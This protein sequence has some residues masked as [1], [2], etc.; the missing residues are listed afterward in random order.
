MKIVLAILRAPVRLLNWFWWYFGTKEIGYLAL[1]MA[2]VLFLG[3]LNAGRHVCT[4]TG[5]C[6]CLCPLS[7]G[8]VWIE[9]FVSLFSAEK[10]SQNWVTMLL[11]LVTWLVGGGA[12]VSVMVG[13]FYKKVAGELRWWP[14]L[15][16]DH[17]VVLGWDDGVLME[18]VNELKS[19]NPPSKCYVITSRPVKEIE[20]S[21]ESARISTSSICVYHGNYDD[22]REWKDNLRVRNAKRVFIMGEHEEDAHDARVRILFEKVNQEVGKGNDDSDKIRVNIHDFGLARELT[23]MNE[24]V[25]ENFHLNWANVLTDKLKG[26]SKGKGFDLYI[27]GFG[28]MG[29]AVAI[30]SVE[31]NL[32]QAIFVSDDDDKKL[33]DEKNRFIHQFADVS[34]GLD[35]GNS[36]SGSSL[37]AG[38]GA[39]DV[40]TSTPQGNR[41]TFNGVSIAFIDEW[42]QALKQMKEIFDYNKKSEDNN[43]AS[44]DDSQKCD[45]KN[46]AIVVAKKRSEKGMLCMMDVIRQL[47]KDCSN[48]VWLA[49]DQ[50]VDGYSV[51]SNMKMCIGNKIPVHLF[52]MKRGCEWQPSKKEKCRCTATQE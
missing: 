21:F 45:K 5:G 18:L 38:G 46:I 25:Y 40:V 22:E 6:I 3:A 2:V 13:R 4:C 10:A 51:D 42:D 24:K 48:A 32:P 28:A 29:K 9:S 8:G 33:E 12:L 23:K 34:G 1:I 26:W 35:S 15:V 49:L 31:K 7:R 41:V 52:G 43:Q 14:W 16:D 47:E 11:F 20:R 27:V 17:I 37:A 19:K 44:G 36:E 30:T 50:E 39:V